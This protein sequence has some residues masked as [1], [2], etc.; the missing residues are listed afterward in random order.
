[1]P[2]YHEP[3]GSVHDDPC[4]LRPFTA[5][6]LEKLTGIPRRL[7]WSAAREK[8]LPSFR[9]NRKV[10]FPRPA[11]LRIL[12]EGNPSSLLAAREEGNADA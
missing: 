9:I 5:E 3:A 1:M 8:A 10:M 6:D 4:D 2:S 7:W 11:L 12:A